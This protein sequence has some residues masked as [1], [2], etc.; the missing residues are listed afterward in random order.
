MTYKD[1]LYKVST[2]IDV[3]SHNGAVDWASSKDGW[4]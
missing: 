2:G 1:S 4:N 3:S